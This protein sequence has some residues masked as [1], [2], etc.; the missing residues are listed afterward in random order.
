MGARSGR[1][2]ACPVKG[3]ADRADRQTRADN[4]NWSRSPL[5]P[6]YAHN[7]I[8]TA[9]AHPDPGTRH[10]PTGL[11]LG[12]C[13]GLG[14]SLRARSGH[15]RPTHHPSRRP[16]SLPDQAA[17]R[18]GQPRPVAHRPGR[19]TNLAGMRPVI[20]S[21]A[22]STGQG[23]PLFHCHRRAMCAVPTTWALACAAG[24]S[25]PSPCRLRSLA[26]NLP[27]RPAI[28]LNRVYRADTTSRPH[29]NRR[30]IKNLP[31][32]GADRVGSFASP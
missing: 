19:W 17:R 27:L 4:K 31:G 5:P 9:I 16:R 21:V 1:C 28:C 8:P 14:S 22:L 15:G 25:P 26:W 23:R 6:P 30:P 20:Q 29:T 12:P 3:V 2:G 7:A 24:S 32:P 11:Y 18:S 13:R 10:A